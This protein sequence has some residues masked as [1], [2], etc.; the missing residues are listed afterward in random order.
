MSWQRLWG[1]N[2]QAGGWYA[3]CK[4]LVKLLRGAHCNARAASLAPQGSYRPHMRK[5]SSQSSQK[6]ETLLL[7]LLMLRNPPKLF[8]SLGLC[9]RPEF[10]QHRVNAREQA[11]APLPCQHHLPSCLGEKAWVPPSSFF[12]PPLCSVFI[13]FT[14]LS[15][16]SLMMFLLN[17]SFFWS[18]AQA[19]TSD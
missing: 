10:P 5:A 16:Q 17:S 4:S 11:V 7:Y 14:S 6:P 9:R 8:S 1:R 3:H 12:F 2:W 18:L 15:Q 13:Y 19:G